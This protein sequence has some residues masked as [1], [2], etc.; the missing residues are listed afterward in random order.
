[1][2]QPTAAPQSAISPVLSFAIQQERLSI[3]YITNNI[4]N[5]TGC[6][7]LDEYKKVEIAYFARTS[8][9]PRIIGGGTKTDFIGRSI[10]TQPRP[11]AE[12]LQQSL[13]ES[14]FNAPSPEVSRNCYEKAQ[15][16]TKSVDRQ[17]KLP[18]AMQSPVNKHPIDTKESCAPFSNSNSKA[19][20]T[21]KLIIQDPFLINL[22]SDHSIAGCLDNRIAQ[23]D[24]PGDGN[25]LF[26][27]T[28]LCLQKIDRVPKDLTAKQL[29]QS[30]ADLLENY[31]TDSKLKKALR[32]E[33]EEKYRT[34][35]VS[36]NEEILSFERIYK[37]ISTQGEKLL[38]EETLKQNRNQLTKLE[39][40][41]EQI[42]NFLQELDESYDQYFDSYINELKTPE[43]FAGNAAI[44]ALSKIFEVDIVVH[45]EGPLMEQIYET[46]NQ[47]EHKIKLMNVGKH[48][49]SLISY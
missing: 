18:L 23:V 39:A 19:A 3:D 6:K 14:L 49:N 46:E 30:A 13:K 47:F 27:A 5:L 32:Q 34:D 45:A 31:K 15:Q 12:N 17:I 43:C 40:I 48:Y 10:L 36:I 37:S 20:A 25:C 24:V 2:S 1:M 4:E 22:P 42:A 35:L 21:P 44:E 41:V 7:T 28:L 16:L 9:G 26:H 11:P 29:R 33:L 8:R 38:L